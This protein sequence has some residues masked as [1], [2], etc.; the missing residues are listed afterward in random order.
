[1]PFLQEVIHKL[2]VGGGLRFIRI[3]AAVLA[4]TLLTVG[5][6]SR[7][8]KNMATQEAMDGAGQRLHHALHPPLQHPS[9]EG[10]HSE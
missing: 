4:L 7:A 8:F 2:E 5:Y 9:H 3:G 10:T 6:N 1:M